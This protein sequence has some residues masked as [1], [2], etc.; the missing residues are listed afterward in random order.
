MGGLVGGVAAGSS[1]I[2]LWALHACSGSVLARVGACLRSGVW[3]AA[4][5]LCRWLRLIDA[6]QACLSVIAHTGLFCESP[7]S[8]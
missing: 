2:L 1:L 8:C 5:A 4:R 6:W 3:L 7:L